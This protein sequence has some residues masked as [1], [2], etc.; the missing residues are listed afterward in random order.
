[1][2]YYNTVDIFKL[3]IA[4]SRDFTDYDFMAAKCDT[5]LANKA[6]DSNVAIQIVSG[7]ARGADKLGER[8]AKERGYLVA[9]FK[10]DW[11]AEPKRAGYIRNMQM[12][13]YADV[14][15]AFNLGTRGTGHM[16]KIAKQS[17]LQVRVINVSPSIVKP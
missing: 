17:G 12:A 10:A 1:M 11:Q 2:G 3:I 5:L 4:G 8:Y 15:I 7:D 9:I 6:N 14:L 16:I 13:S